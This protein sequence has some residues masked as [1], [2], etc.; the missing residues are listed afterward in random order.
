M[1]KHLSGRAASPPHSDSSGR[2]S[3]IRAKST[4]GG[5]PK[6][7]ASG[8]STPLAEGSSMGGQASPG[9]QTGTPKSTG[10]GGG[11]SGKRKAPAGSTGAKVKRTAQTSPLATG[12]STG[13][14]R[15]LTDAVIQTAFRNCNKEHIDL[16]ELLAEVV[17]IAGSRSHTELRNEIQPAFKTI[18]KLVKRDE[19]TLVTLRQPGN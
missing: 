19:K 1:L 3:S 4:I 9:G 11:A 14:P 2:P 7:T 12:S 15:P 16:K 8:K 18:L 13:A 10:S 6:G 5:R 17:K